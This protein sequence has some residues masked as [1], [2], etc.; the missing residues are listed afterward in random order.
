MHLVYEECGCN[1]SAA[2]RLYRERYPNAERHPKYRVFVHVHQSYSGGRL[3]H[4]RK[5]GGRRQADYEDMVLEEVENDAGTSVHAIEM[6]TGV[7]KSIA[8]RILKRRQYHPCY[9][10][11]VKTLLSQDYLPS[12]EFCRRMLA[13]NQE[14]SAIFEKIRWT[15]ET[16]CKK[17]GYF[18]LQTYMDGIL[19]THI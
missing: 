14:R 19:K 2:A 6:N 16:T 7:P 13:K 10:Q 1:A 18:N 15:D 17:D 5:S 9:V 3:P 8:Q 4:V 11:R 12:M